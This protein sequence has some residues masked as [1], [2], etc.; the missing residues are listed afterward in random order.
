MFVVTVAAGTLES[1]F[2][3]GAG[4]VGDGDEEV[5]ASEDVDGG[6]DGHLFA[7]I[8]GVGDEADGFEDSES[9]MGGGI[10]LNAFCGSAGVFDV[11]RMEIVLFGEFVELGVFG[12]VELI[13]GHGSSCEGS[14]YV[15]LSSSTQRRPQLL[16]DQDSAPRGRGR[17]KR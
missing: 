4:G 10:D 11:K 7:R 2:R 8:F 12:V 6:E 13:P 16:H 3:A 9:V 15:R 17:D 5:F 14:T 1:L